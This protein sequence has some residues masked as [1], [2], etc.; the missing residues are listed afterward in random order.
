MPSHGLCFSWL[1][2]LRNVF[3]G[4]LFTALSFLLRTS[5]K[6]NILTDKASQTEYCCEDRML[7]RTLK[8][9][10]TVKSCMD[11]LTQQYWLQT[12]FSR[13]QIKTFKCSRFS[14]R[15]RGI[16]RLGSAFIFLRWFQFAHMCIQVDS[17]HRWNKESISKCLIW[18][19]FHVILRI[20]SP[21]ILLKWSSE[22]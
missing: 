11:S 18:C 13:S 15:F 3:L 17:L 9:Y 22:S 12:S 10:A 14:V 19:R 8:L 1:R 20:D 6:K 16:S 7:L 5:H 4:Y 21:R 2:R